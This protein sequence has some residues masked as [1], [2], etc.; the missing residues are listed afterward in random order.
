M[1]NSI[2]CT[3]FEDEMV[4]TLSMKSFRENTCPH[5]NSVVIFIPFF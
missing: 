2:N 3:L 4:N 1:V 5:I